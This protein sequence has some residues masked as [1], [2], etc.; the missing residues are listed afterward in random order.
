[1]K[2]LLLSTYE[3]GHQ[4][5]NLGWP[6]AALR[7][8][9]FRVASVDLSVED[10][11]GAEA[12]GASFIGI[13]VPMHTAMRLGVEA[14]RQVRKLN[15]ATHINFYGH[16]AYLNEAY[17][18]GS[19]L[20]DS[21]LAGEIEP[22]LVRIARDLDRYSPSGPRVRLKRPDYP[23]PDRTGL[24]GLDVYAG[25][26]IG[27]EIRL[28]GYTEATRGCLHTCTHCPVVPVYNGRFFAVPV[29][30]VLEDIRSQVAAGAEHI[31]F[32]DPDFLNGP[33]HS[34]RIVRRMQGEFPGLTFD[35][36]AKVEHLID[37]HDL[38]GELADLGALFAVSAFESTSDQ[39]LAKLRKG[40]TA[41]DMDRALNLAAN[42][43]LEIQPTW[44][45]FTPW[46]TLEDY[47][48]MLA[49]IY[50]RNLVKITPAVQ[51]S[52][53]LLVPPRSALLSTPDAPFFGPPDPENF[54]H[55]WSHPDPCMDELHT[56][57]SGLVEERI[58][59]SPGEMFAEIEALAY[60][61]ADREPPLRSLKTM[62]PVPSPRLT[63][64]WFC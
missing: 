17:L 31:T 34:M 37:H 59:L 22:E 42:A 64:D 10:F 36:T 6:V 32:G 38:L 61:I 50:D 44:V 23:V 60:R 57:V 16:Y 53:R 19:G 39:V 56:G 63:E 41:A 14:A 3:L 15:P 30:T 21:V 45:A 26:R 12:A 2:I 52:V 24:A 51:F 8:A 25:L 55:P 4:P 43:G 62:L 54:V 33:T 18:I 35:F 28:A 27:G 47:L 48:K 9:G 1:M 29:E 5:I 11:P 58:G 13:S 46:T 40:H 49:W 7:S 20:A